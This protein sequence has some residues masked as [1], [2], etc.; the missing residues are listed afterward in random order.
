MFTAALVTG[1]KTWRQ[2]SVHPQIMDKQNVVQP[3]NGILLSLKKEGNCD[4]GYNMD[5]T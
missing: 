5:E 4:T 3:H 1:A 2:P